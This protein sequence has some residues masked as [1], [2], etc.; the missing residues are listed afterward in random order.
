MLLLHFTKSLLLK[1]AEKFKTKVINEDEFLN[2]IK[3]LPGK[4][5]KYEIHEEPKVSP[6]TKKR[7]PSEASKPTESS[8][9]SVKS[10][11]RTLSNVQPLKKE[12]LQKAGDFMMWVDKYKPTSI[13][14]IIGQ[15][16]AS[17]NV[18][19]LLKWLQNWHINNRTAAGK[20]KPKP[21]FSPWGGG[22]PTGSIY[23][24]ALLSGPPGVGKTTSATLVCK[25]SLKNVDNYMVQFFSQT[26][27]C[28]QWL[29][30]I[31]SYQ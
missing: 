23:K 26:K 17:S 12:S 7:I 8:K 31:Q 6:P 21:K 11:T 1:Q 18:Q 4:R 22:D 28:N 20:S 13:K 15:Q 29:Y 30:S 5:S 10:E 16:G 14:Q 25:V 3:T 24:A 9:S 27:K 19:K 2:L